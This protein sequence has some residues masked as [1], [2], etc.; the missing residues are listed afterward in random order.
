MEIL[1]LPATTEIGLPQV[2]SARLLA[3]NHLNHPQLDIKDLWLALA[4]V[5]LSLV[6]D[7][8]WRAHRISLLLVG[9]I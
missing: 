7:A 4:I 8:L 6:A 5:R 3:L 1:V 2:A 9:R